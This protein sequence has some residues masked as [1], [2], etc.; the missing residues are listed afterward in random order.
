MDTLLGRASS[1]FIFVTLLPTLVLA[2][3]A[4]ALLASGAPEQAPSATDAIDRLNNLTWRECVALLFVVIVA[5]VGLHPIQTPLIQ[6]LEGYWL[7]LPWG[8]TATT[9]ATKRYEELFLK[10]KKDE[11]KQPTDPAS[12]RLASSARLRLDWLPDH[13]TKLLPTSLGNALRAGE[14]RATARY[15]ME[16]TVAMPR[17]IP[18]LPPD[19]R[20]LLSDRR[21]QL[22]AAAH[23]CVMSLLCVLIGTG[24]LL[25]T[26]HWLYVPFVACLIAWAC[27]R[28]AVAAARGYCT[29]MAALVDL[30]HRDLWCAL[31]LEPPS[32]LFEERQRASVLTAYLSGRSLTERAAR[33]I[34][35]QAPP[36]S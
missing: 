12:F 6:V 25:P 5:A 22:D 33:S 31:A 3:F 26:G 15:G 2:A 32:S 30:H 14:E 1:R 28:S 4:G 24:L 10:L 23:L 9:I 17:L 29:D 18:L 35:W 34:R 8:E 27:Y 20:D 19:Q 21:T 7:N 11:N 36:P 13:R 16:V